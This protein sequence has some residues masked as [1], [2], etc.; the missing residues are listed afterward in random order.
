MDICLIRLTLIIMNNNNGP[1]YL[2]VFYRGNL[3]QIVSPALLSIQTIGN[4]VSMPCAQRQLCCI[5]PHSLSPPQSTAYLIARG[6][7]GPKHTSHGTRTRW[8][9]YVRC[10]CVWHDREKAGSGAGWSCWVGNLSRA[11]QRTNYGLVKNI[12]VE[13]GLPS[14][15]HYQ[16]DFWVKL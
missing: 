8:R 9:K 1:S 7:R 6:K 16:V 14:I 2:V 11:S 3:S 4:L 15:S 13:E 12:E 10:I 5:K